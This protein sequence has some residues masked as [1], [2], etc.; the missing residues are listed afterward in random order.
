MK[1]SNFISI[2]SKELTGELSPDELK[3]L[4]E[5]KANFAFNEE[6]TELKNSWDTAQTYRS[7]IDID[8]NAAFNR[9]S[10][11][12]NI[13]IIGVASESGRSDITSLILKITVALTILLVGLFVV[14]NF[15]N[16]DN[17]TFKNNTD[18]I[19]ILTTSDNIQLALTPGSEFQIIDGEIHVTEGVVQ[20]S[21]NDSEFTSESQNNIQILSESKSNILDELSL[22]KGFYLAG[23]EFSNSEANQAY[24]I[25]VKKTG[26]TQELGILTGTL[27]YNRDNELNTLSEN[28]SIIFS[29]NNEFIDGDLSSKASVN[30]IKKT[31]NF[32]NT[33]LK[34]VFT[35]MET[36]FGVDIEV[37][38][39]YPKACH[40]TAEN[41][42][43]PSIK[44]VFA[45][46][47]TSFNM[48]VNRIGLD[49]YE[50]YNISCK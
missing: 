11:K 10:Q 25:S 16:T 1:E 15:L 18:E 37:N 46:L 4:N 24:S 23:T 3:Q 19:K 12:Y 26:N 27:N 5:L 9:F 47:H 14:S 29:D 50:V 45:L 49:K 42:Q 48:G 13:P 39:S 44:D 30:L 17:P 20:L 35:E 8:V 21:I 34:S 7:D 2:L 31:L 43:N 22:E 36:Y 6:R 41:L 28:S 38:S 33:P 32:N 40:F